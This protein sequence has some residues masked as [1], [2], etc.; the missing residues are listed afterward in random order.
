MQLARTDLGPDETKEL[1]Y[2]MA[3]AK[4]LKALDLLN[5]KFDADSARQ[6]V[7]MARSKH[8][9]L[10]GVLPEQ[11]TKAALRLE[12]TRPQALASRIACLSPA[13]ARRC[14]PTA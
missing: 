4:E 13:R 1:L 5:N 2:V 8:I 9:S 6:L 7:A 12:P 11:H 3:E 10:C 14:L